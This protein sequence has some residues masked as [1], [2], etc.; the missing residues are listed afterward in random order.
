MGVKANSERES[1]H[2]LAVPTAPVAVLGTHCCGKTCFGNLLRSYYL[3]INKRKNSRAYVGFGHSVVWWESL[4]KVFAVIGVFTKQNKLLRGEQCTGSLA[5][6]I[7]SFVHPHLARFYWNL[8]SL[9]WILSLEYCS[10]QNAYS[11]MFFLI[12]ITWGRFIGPPHSLD[13]SFNSFFVVLF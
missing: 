11:W 3:K 4:I 1:L 9:K 5:T 10:F 7:P 6:I 13:S 12:H 8:F 2:V